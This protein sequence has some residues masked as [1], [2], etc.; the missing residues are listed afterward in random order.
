MHTLAMKLAQYLSDHDLSDQAFADLIGRHRSIVTRY[1]KGT[2]CPSLEAIGAIH[3]VTE[4][5]VSFP[6]FM[7]KQG[8]LAS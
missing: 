6:D 3:R 5:A 8:E 2:V 1:R 7:S 4:G